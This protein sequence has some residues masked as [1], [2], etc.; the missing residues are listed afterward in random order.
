MNKFKNIAVEI[1][2]NQKIFNK[3]I[4]EK[5]IFKSFDENNYSGKGLLITDKYRYDGYFESGKK[6]ILGTEIYF[7]GDEFFS[8]YEFGQ[9]N[10]T[11]KLDNKEKVITGNY[12]NG[13]IEGTLYINYKNKYKVIMADFIN[14]QLDGRVVINDNN[15]TKIC[16][17]S[18]NYFLGIKGEIQFLYLYYNLNIENEI[19][20]YGLDYNNKSIIDKKLNILIHENRLE[21]IEYFNQCQYLFLFDK[22]ITI[23]KISKVFSKFGETFCFNKFNAFE[24]YELKEKIEL[25]FERSLE[26][27]ISENSNDFIDEDYTKYY[28]SEYLDKKNSILEIYKELYNINE[29]IYES[30]SNA[31]TLYLCLEKLNKIYSNWQ[32]DDID[33][34]LD[35][36]ANGGG[37]R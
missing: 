36:L 16:I 18:K 32:Q 20:I 24:I 31:K 11:F 30:Y 29:N 17:F 37:W 9:R 8:F 5:I 21:L 22:N 33:S 10:G 4:D 3:N 26:D 1:F 14:D 7:D 2:S 6:H 27:Y 28:I 34:E 23:N 25:F 12:I 19:E 15:T 13:K 35:W